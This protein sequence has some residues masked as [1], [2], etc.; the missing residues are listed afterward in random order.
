PPPSSWILLLSLHYALPILG[1]VD[2]LVTFR[3]DVYRPCFQRTY[4]SRVHYR[5]IS[6]P[7]IFSALW[8]S[9]FGG[10]GIHFERFKN[11]GIWDAMEDRKSTRLN[12][13]QVSILYAG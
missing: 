3:R 13:N 5:S 8:F 4:H 11:A 2:C 7:T 12:S 6:C 10:T 9:I 1:L